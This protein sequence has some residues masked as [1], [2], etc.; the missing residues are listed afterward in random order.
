ML[1]YIRCLLEVLARGGSRG[2]QTPGWRTQTAQRD[3][4]S[5]V[6]ANAGRAFGFGSQKVATMERI[7][8][9][10]TFALRVRSRP[11]TRGGQAYR[12]RRGMRTTEMAGLEMLASLANPRRL[13]GLQ[14]LP[15]VGRRC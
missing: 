10:V 7:A 4:Q 9:I 5:T 3:P 6:K 15:E 8:D 12:G 2:C 13:H 1:V 11:A 14:R